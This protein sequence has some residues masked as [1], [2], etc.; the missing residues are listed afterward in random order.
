MATNCPPQMASVEDGGKSSTVA[1]GGTSD[2]GSVVLDRLGQI[3]CGI[4]GHD[5]LIQFE[6]HRMFLK[7]ASCGHESPGWKLPN[8]RPVA[9]AVAAGSRAP[10]PA[11]FDDVKRV[12]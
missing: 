2:I 10:V 6:Q 12:A 11:I 8:R 4:H 7:C 5:N 9:K 1:A 3:V